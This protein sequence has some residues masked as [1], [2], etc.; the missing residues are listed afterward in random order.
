[1]TSDADILLALTRYL[2]RTQDADAIKAIADQAFAD[3][4]AGKSITSLSFEGGAVSALQNCSPAVLLNA[5]EDA[6]FALGE[7]GAQ[8]SQSQSIFP[9]F[10]GQV[11]QA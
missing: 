11:I 1:M 3:L 6:L 4:Q 7:S 2:L 10:G 5:C 9:R 8:T